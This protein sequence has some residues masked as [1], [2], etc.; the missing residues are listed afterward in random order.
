MTTSRTMAAPTV[1]RV[2]AVAEAIQDV[3][4]VWYRLVTPY[5]WRVWFAA[6]LGW[7][8]DGYEAFALT[9]V[10]IPAMTTLLPG[11][12]PVERTLTGG[13]VISGMLF[14]WA[15]G[16]VVGGILSD[17]LGRKRAMILAILT[18]A[19]FTG[20]AGVAQNWQMLLIF[21]FLTGLGI[22]AEWANGTALI[23]ETWPARARPIGLSLMQSGFGWG[24]FI[25]AGLWFWLSTLGPDAWRFIFFCGAL[26]ALVTLFIRRGVH[27]SEKW[28]EADRERADLKARRE[29]GATL[30]R[31]EEQKT[32]FTLAAVFGE[33]R[34]RRYLIATTVLSLATVVAYWANSG[35]IPAYAQSVA[36]AEGQANPAQSAAIVTLWYT[37][38][39]IIGYLVMGFIADRIGRRGLVLV[40]F[41]GSL[42]TTPITFFVPHT[43][44]LL[45]WLA[46]VNGFFTLGQFAWMSIYLPELF[47]TVVRGTAASFV[48]STTRYFAAI[49][50]FIAGA[51]IASFGGFGQSATIFALAYLVALPALLF[52]PETTGQPMPE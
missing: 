10:L 7:L 4:Q 20:L 25:A 34:L 51:L 37:A 49:G 29:A 11:A 30:S 26:P 45:S 42:I 48:F 19:I 44:N 41:V 8:F 33:P 21:R 24:Q 35:W 5:Q 14:G 28:E 23:S 46:L 39:A 12:T 16:G 47:P 17:Y 3:G 36:Q 1:G 43:I 38:G 6:S 18:Y 9:L 15:T 27:E 52:L 32:R 22:G 2:G 13:L 50:P 31:D 40:W